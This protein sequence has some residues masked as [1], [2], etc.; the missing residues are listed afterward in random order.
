MRYK[1]EKV[2]AINAY[3]SFVRQFCTGTSVIYEVYCEIETGMF[4]RYHE[5]QYVGYADQLH[6]AEDIVLR[7]KGEHP[8]QLAEEE[9]RKI[10][11]EIVRIYD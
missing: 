7:A 1:I 6:K 8:D 3:E 5:W 9:A 4:I 10:P 2:S 11:R